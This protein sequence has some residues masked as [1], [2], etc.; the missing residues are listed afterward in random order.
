MYYYLE[1]KY[2][3]FQMYSL[4]SHRQPKTWDKYLLAQFTHISYKKR[5]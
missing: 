5:D 4:V 1:E 3:E 2:Q